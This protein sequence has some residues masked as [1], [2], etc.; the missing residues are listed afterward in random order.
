M[1]TAKAVPFFFV[2][3]DTPMQQIPRTLSPRVARLRG[4]RNDKP[5]QGTPNSP[6]V[7]VLS[8]LPAVIL[9]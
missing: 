5:Y 9:R 1:G 4:A 3:T 6:L 2:S 8:R 7:H